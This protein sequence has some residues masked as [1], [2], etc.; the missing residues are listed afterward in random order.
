[1]LTVLVAIIVAYLVLEVLVGALAGV[2]GIGGMA[3]GGLFSLI[4]GKK[5]AVPC[6]CGHVFKARP[7]KKRDWNVTCPYCG[8]V[9]HVD[10]RRKRTVTK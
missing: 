6:A 1:M 5:V 8:E 10:T 4:F 2:L 3:G 7:K 9:H